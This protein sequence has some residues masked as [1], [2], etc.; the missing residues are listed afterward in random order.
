MGNTYSYVEKQI[1]LFHVN[2]FQHMW[3]YQYFTFL[4]IVYKGETIEPKKKNLYENLI[5]QSFIQQKN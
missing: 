4:Q 3:A 1:M 2:F 5:L